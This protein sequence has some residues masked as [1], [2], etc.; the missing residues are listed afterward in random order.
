M[1]ANR[2]D[3]G[4]ALPMVSAVGLTLLGLG[5]VGAAFAAMQ[6]SAWLYFGAMPVLAPVWLQAGLAGQ[7]YAWFFASL[8]ALLAGGLLFH[9]F[10]AYLGLALYRRRPWARP[11][12]LA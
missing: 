6:L 5:S 1:F 7:V 4:L 3:D 12:R 8:P 2:I 11:G 9:V 10:V